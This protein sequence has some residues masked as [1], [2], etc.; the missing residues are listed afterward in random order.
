MTKCCISSSKFTTNSIRVQ[1]IW[2]DLDYTSIPIFF[3][4]NLIKNISKN[5]IPS[6]MQLD[7]KGMLFGLQ[8][9]LITLQIS[10]L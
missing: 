1:N 3:N 4:E 9:H 8:D 7:L 10:F 5:L 6:K 2:D